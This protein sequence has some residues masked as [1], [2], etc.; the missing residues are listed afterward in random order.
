MKVKTINK[1]I[2]KKFDEWLASITDE[3]VRKL[4]EKGSIL[5][6]GSIASML[7][8]EPVNDFDFYFKD[9]DTTKAV[10][11]Y[12]VAKF[13]ENPPPTMKFP[14][15]KE[16]EMGVKVISNSHSYED[17]ITGGASAPPRVR[18]FI[19]SA[20]VAGE[21]TN[22][23]ELNGEEGDSR[24]TGE[25]EH[26]YQYFEQQAP[27]A[28]E[29]YVDQVMA[30]KQEKPKEKYDYRP[31]FLT[32]NAISLNG[33]IQLVI[34]FYGKPEEIHENYDYVHA[35]NY[36][37]SWDRQ[38]TLRTEALEC[39]LTKELRYIG[40]KYPIC[41]LVRARKFIQRDWTI[42]AGQFLKISMQISELNLKDYEVLKEQLVGMDVAYF[43]QVLSA[44]KEEDPEKINAAYLTE[45]ID[46]IFG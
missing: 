4:V 7:L 26:P 39:L 27:E 15:G 43:M 32:D 21:A 14:D 41:S 10:A 9:L 42:N 11:E 5:T 8:R 1:T 18:I 29:E 2:N 17:I 12:Y 30:S 28:A 31:I 24:E 40:S 34:R 35:T 19:R 33:D 20:G 6:G 46:R 13:K 44:L 38:V 22:D 23:Q 3:N 37:T 36:W 16:V 45:I 25:N